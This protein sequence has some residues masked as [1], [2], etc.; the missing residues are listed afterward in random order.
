[1][2][3]GLD[4]AWA[5]HP[6]VSTVKQ[7][8]YSFVCRYLSNDPTKNLT[9]AELA[10]IRNAG[11]SIVVVWETTGDRMKAG[12]A[13]GKADAEEANNLVNDLDMRGVPIYFACDYDAPPSDQD[14]INA[15]LDG[16]ASVIG[17]N[18][19]GMYGGYWPLSRAFDAGKCKYGWQ[20]SAW[21]GG[22]WESRAQIRQTGTTTITGESADVDVTEVEGNGDFGQSPR[23][24]TTAAHYSVT[25]LPPGQWTGQI[26]LHGTGTDGKEWHTTTDDGANWSTPRSGD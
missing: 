3:K 18:R 24:E 6:N 22:N 26:N 11:L 15:Y 1:V 2:S 20:T 13:A 5:P 14:A 10:T 19:V 23:P 16:V 25:K 12:N 9:S 4:Y 7:K 17:A 21:S 8:G